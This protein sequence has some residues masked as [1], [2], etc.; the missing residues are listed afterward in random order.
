[1]SVQCALAV[2]ADPND[3]PQ[4]SLLQLTQQQ[5]EQEHGHVHKRQAVAQVLED[6][7]HQPAPATKLC[8]HGLT[9][10]GASSLLSDW[11]DGYAMRVR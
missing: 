6:Q 2:L 8:A 10:L 3:S 11:M 4:A 1:M 9:T 7:K 5:E